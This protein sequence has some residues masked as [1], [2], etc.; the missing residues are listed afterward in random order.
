MLN[1]ELNEKSNC[2]N[3]FLH[4][5]RYR[6]VQKW[7]RRTYGSGR[8]R[9]LEIGVGYG[10][11]LDELCP[12]LDIEY[13]GIELLDGF[14]QEA[15]RRHPPSAVC[16]M[17][18]G[19]VLDGEVQSRLTGSFDVVIALETCEHI[20]AGELPQVFTLL[21]SRISCSYFISSVPIEIGLSILIKN[22][23][24][25]LLS[26]GRFREYSLGETLNAALLRIHKLPPHS[27]EAGYLRHKGFDWRAYRYLLHQDFEIEQTRSLPFHWMPVCLSTNVIFVAL[28]RKINVNTN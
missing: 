20:R 24:S 14:Y 17:I 13:T 1:H 7:L 5:R 6:F 9:I 22:L 25:M 27:S 21:R 18:R 3:R 10:R 2:I 19:S 23:G 15:E 16:R 12:D 28:P 11:L 4:G 8:I 26:Y